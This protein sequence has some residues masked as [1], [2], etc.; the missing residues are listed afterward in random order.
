LRQ[1]GS[2]LASV[3][4]A[5]CR[6][7]IYR[8]TQGFPP[9]IN[10]LCDNALLICMAQEMRRVNSKIL[11]KAHEAW[12]TDLVFTPKASKALTYRVNK[13]NKP[14][15]VVAGSLV[16]IILLGI[17]VIRS[18]FSVDNLKS[19]FQKIRSVV[20]TASG[21]SAP[22]VVQREDLQKPENESL[23][24]QQSSKPKRAPQLS[25][26][27]LVSADTPS[28]LP[29]GLS[30][31]GIAGE[32]SS[33]ERQSSS[34]PGK[35]NPKPDPPG[36]PKVAAKIST[37]PEALEPQK[38]LNDVGKGPDSSP[39]SSPARMA[40][41]SNELITKAGDTLF[42]IVN[43]HYPDNKKLGLEALILANP[44]L[45]DENKI[46]PGQTLYLPEINPDN[47]TIRL[48]DKLLYTVYGRYESANILKKDSS[49][50]E[51]REVLFVLRATKD[52]KR[53]MVHRVFLGGYATEAELE[54]ALVSANPKLDKGVGQANQPVSIMNNQ[55][56]ALSATGADKHKVSPGTDV[57]QIHLQKELKNVPVKKFNDHIDDAFNK[58]V[59]VGQDNR[60]AGFADTQKNVHVFSPKV[61]LLALSEVQLR[62]V[63]GENHIFFDKIYRNSTIE[64]SFNSFIG[65]GQANQST[66]S[67][68]N[69]GNIFSFVGNK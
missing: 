20:Q 4:E 21:P 8:M 10:Q 54:K 35:N 46:L 40:P 55:A 39:G 69:Q 34:P 27:P 23:R 9:L 43:R 30:H 62:Q 65:V 15:M 49:R 63:T 61:G 57:T 52:S 7:L 1:V 12:Q 51:K 41:A 56:G 64:K 3:F 28:P 53:I 17:F 33:G 45:T 44:E 19:V 47:V 42:R 2:S 58:F 24:L 13:P 6:K 14:L 5:K 50:L 60:D 37:V 59:V 29:E 66:G 26:G 67:I 48:R 31:I 11:K 22:I 68:N 25:L 18:G 16:V 32:P 38:A 36:G